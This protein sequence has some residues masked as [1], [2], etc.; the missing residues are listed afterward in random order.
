[1]AKEPTPIRALPSFRTARL[2]GIFNVLFGAEI[3]LCGLLW[4]SYIITLPML[5]RAIQTVQKQQEDRAE[6]SKK[7]ELEALDEEEKG[8]KTE[9]EKVEIE[10]RRREVKSRPRPFTAA[11]MDL[12]TMGMTDQK[13]LAWSIA[14]VTSGLV[15]NILLLASGIGL[16][17]WKPWSRPLG[18]WTSALK[19]VRL[20]LLYG[21]FVVAIAPMIGQK[22]G[23]AVSQ[24]MTQ[25]Q[26]GG[27]PKG[28]TL[29]TSTLVQIYTITY[30][31][32][33]AGMIVCGA[34]YPAVAIW[35]L[36]RPGVKAACSGV[37]QLPKEPHQ[38]C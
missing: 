19:I 29:A 4:G 10:A 14:E 8:A 17:S 1:M 24:M 11:S 23:Q 33:G 12:A 34:V 35:L 31:L 38:P 26:I 5:G 3:F 13:T 28:A 27:M 21:F 2:V 36:T 7:A 15:L 16:L 22:Y 9:V 37:F 18:V 25:G 6:A 32:L 20:A 30:S